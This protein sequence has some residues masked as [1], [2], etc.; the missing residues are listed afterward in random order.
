[1]AI[2]WAGYNRGYALREDQRSRCDLT[3]ARSAVAEARRA[4]THHNLHPFPFGSGRAISTAER[5]RAS[6]EIS[7]VQFARGVLRPLPWL[8]G[9]AAGRGG[10]EHEYLLLPQAGESRQYERE[11]LFPV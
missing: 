4:K 3:L 7:R 10:A 9:T 11:G 6:G 2:P 1:M 5:R 8:H